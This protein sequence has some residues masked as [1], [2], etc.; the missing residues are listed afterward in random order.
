M[1]NYVNITCLVLAL[2]IPGLGYS[3][4]G[5]PFNTALAS[6]IDSINVLA[7]KS[8]GLSK[9]PI[10]QELLE[11][12]LAESKRIGYKKGEGTAC[13]ALGNVSYATR[14]FSKSE[15]YGK[16]AIDIFNEVSPDTMLAKS[17][18]IWARAVWA[19]SRFD[20]AVNGFEK[21]LRLFDRSKDSLGV[22]N[23]FS[24]L[25]IAEEER[26]NYDQAFQYSTKAMRY[27]EQSAWIAIGQLYAD[28]GDYDA[29]LEYYAKITDSNLEILKVQNLGQAYFLKKNNDSALYFYRRYLSAVGDTDKK[30]VSKPYLLIGELY[31]S[32][33]KFDSSLYYL[34]NALNGFR[35]VNDRNWVM[36]SLLELG[37]AYKE[38]GQ[39]NKAYVHIR[40]LLNDAEQT[41]AR[42][43]ARDAHYLLYEIFANHHKTDSAYT[44]LRK[45]TLLNDSIGI[46]M[47]ARK[48]AFFKATGELEQAGLKIDLLNRQ[49]QLQEEE[50]KQAT[51]QKLFL[52][53]GI[54]VLLVLFVIL[55]RNF[56]LKK[57][58]AEHLRKLAE[59][60]L[61][62]QKLQHTK[63][64]SE[65]EMQVLRVQ[66]NPHFIFNSLNSISRFILHN[67]K[68]DADEYLTKFSRLV[69]MI[70]QNSQSSL[71]T[72][73]NELDSLQ[74]YIELEMLRFENRFTYSINVDES[75][76]VGMLKIPPLVIQPFVENSIWHGIMP[77]KDLGHLV[78]HLSSDQDFLLIRITDDGVGRDAYASGRQSQT[79]THKSLGMQITSQR[80]M[81][82]HN[83]K[84]NI[85]PVHVIDLVDESGRAAGTEVTL[86]LSLI[87][88]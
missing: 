73:Q 88:D 6:K 87:Y 74:L 77:K 37:K 7:D 70:L 50:I 12:S 16:L 78:I 33:K 3:W 45:Y 66:M 63:R 19:Q 9:L 32:E 34:Q 18:V 69:R 42:Q 31:L 10:A 67:N 27:K 13:I 47:S 59:N 29:A 36:R 41:G 49:R 26:G 30:A 76:D 62:I 55:G 82:M 65:L 52:L 8:F 58:S 22:G 64:L 53:A 35:E 39:S 84:T 43:Y 75:I 21:A 1:R 44:H 86:T 83:S 61:E 71:I 81:M 28:V 51:Q 72:L 23:T 54:A 56:F 5:T 24:L 2:S 11:W 85:S 38:I 46:D 14:N 17:W 15:Q 80:I 4:Q 60:E 20:E 79:A 57:R 68:S 25:A 48:L 40:E